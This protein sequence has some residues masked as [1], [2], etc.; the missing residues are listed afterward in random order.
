LAELVPSLPPDLGAAVVIAQHM[1]AG[2]TVSLAERLDRRSALPVVEARDG[3]ALHE[4]CVY[5]APGGRHLK[6]TLGVD[7]APRLEVTDEAP[8]HGVRPSADLLFRSIADSY[9]AAAVGVVLTGMGRDGTDGLRWMREAGAVGIVQ[10][11]ATSTV[12]GMPKTALSGA[13]ADAVVALPEMAQAIAR[14]I[15]TVQPR[16]D[17]TLQALPR[18]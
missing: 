13:G 2:F 6:I 3:D 5:V 17:V 11:E 15:G 10:D 14:A 4:N 18:S 16:V 12:Y 9:G 1:P 7:G 8:L